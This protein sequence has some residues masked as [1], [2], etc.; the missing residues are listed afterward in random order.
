MFHVGGISSVSS[1]NGRTTEEE[2]VQLRLVGRFCR[3]RGEIP[4]GVYVSVSLAC[5]ANACDAFIPFQ[6]FA[7]VSP[8]PLLL[9]RRRNERPFRRYSYFK[10]PPTSRSPSFIAPAPSSSQRL[11]SLAL[12]NSVSGACGKKRKRGTATTSLPLTQH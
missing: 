8:S 1:C 7:F 10:A 5:L 6:T 2:G 4:I 12:R 9:R 3:N 11:L